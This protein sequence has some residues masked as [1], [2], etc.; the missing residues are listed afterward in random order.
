MVSMSS[1]QE[2]SPWICHV[3]DYTDTTE[4]VACSV[5]YKVT[6]ANHLVHKTL[7]NEETGLYEI[8]PVCVECTM[9]PF[10]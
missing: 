8:R 5:C 6:C 9:K 2:K 3:C 10:L 7:L 1:G 4:S